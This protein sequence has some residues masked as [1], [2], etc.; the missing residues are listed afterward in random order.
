MLLGVLSKQRSTA[1]GVSRVLHSTETAMVRAVSDM[2]TAGDSELPTVL[3]SL[4]LSAAFDTLD[5][6][7]Y[8]RANELFGF[9]GMAWN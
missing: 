5:R 7:R 6:N 3:L 1:V 2:S 8:L 4:D 9:D